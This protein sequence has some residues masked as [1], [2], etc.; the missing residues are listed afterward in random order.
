MDA[1]VQQLAEALA[2]FEARGPRKIFRDWLLAGWSL[3]EL[4]GPRALAAVV[5]ATR[6]FLPQPDPISRWIAERCVID[7]AAAAAP[8]GS[9]FYAFSSKLFAAFLEWRG[10]NAP[11][12]TIT[13][14]GRR[15]SALGFPVAR[16]GPGGYKARI[17]IRLKAKA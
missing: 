14:F 7:M 1:K 10:P 6:A 16:R 12:M 3:G 17:G 5:A 8:E 4:A 11:P 2:A 9:A 15:L 13:A